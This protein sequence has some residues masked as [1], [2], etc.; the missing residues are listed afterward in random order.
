MDY[1]AFF[2]SANDA[3]YFIGP[4]D[5]IFDCNPRTMEMYGC[6]RGQIIGKTPYD[7]SPP[8][9]PDGRDSR[10]KA[11][12]VIKAAFDGE[13]RSFEWR[14][15]T[16][17]GS[18]FDTEVSLTKIGSGEDAVIQAIV[19]DVTQ[20]KQ[21]EEALRRANRTLFDIIE[22]LPDAT[23]VIDKEK[24][25]IAWNR[26]ME[27]M[28][29][30]KKEDIVG[31]GD[32]AYAIPFYGESRP[33]LMEL[34]ETMDDEIQ[35]RYDF[36][37][38][39]GNR[40]VAETRVPALY[41]GRGAYLR[42]VASPLFDSE[43]HVIGAIEAIRDITE[44]KEAERRLR[45][46]EIK[47]R[48]LVDNANVA[49]LIMRGD[50]FVD[51]NKRAAAIFRCSRDEIIGEAVHRFYPAD[52]PDKHSSTERISQ[53]INAVLAGD[54]QFF[55]AKVCRYD[56]TPF[57][58][59]LNLSR[60]E[61]EGECLIQ[62]I[63]RD[64]TYRKE[65]E[66]ILETKSLNLEEVNTALRVLLQERARDKDELEEK[67]VRNVK[68]L[69]LPYIDTLKQ[70]YV[71]NTQLVYL[72][73]VETNLKNI[74]SPFMQKMTTI[75]PNLTPT[76]IKVANLIRDG[77]TVKE[78]ANIFGISVSSINSHR[79]HIRNKL[80][81]ANKKTNLKTYLLSLTK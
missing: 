20:R 14:H 36:V 28:T 53:R 62:T 60:I 37:K 29:G 44:R 2:E 47:Y 3:I 61:L 13:I 76:E 15:C 67:I 7:F 39:E 11:L 54:P 22:F 19:R 41:E 31:K 43:G 21:A 79:Q 8:F 42:G 71:D 65:T 59:E 64:I 58:A 66:R 34:V 72:E 73:I 45:E 74:V 5:R 24:R 1:R 68:E 6:T 32:H 40:V 57:D 48:T 50:T 81:L 69:V 75:Y 27:E 9:Q 46:S 70:R 33:L 17:D 16:Y 52:L 38:R 23:V 56:G 80:G 63:I 55:E 18:P 49:I 35:A 4:G 78:I 25:V 30:V 10:S 26:A 77:K 51:C 12:H